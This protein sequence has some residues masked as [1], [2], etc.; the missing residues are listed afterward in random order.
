MERVREWMDI[1][2]CCPKAVCAD[3]SFT[4]EKWKAFFGHHNIRPLPTGPKTPW[5]N[6]A[7]AT[8]RVFK[9]QFAI[10]LEEVAQYPS[11][12]TVTVRQLFARRALLELLC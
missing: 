12:E 4:G 8:I 3:M 9:R 2:Q 6:R 5:P 1:H 11:L 10:M 7:E